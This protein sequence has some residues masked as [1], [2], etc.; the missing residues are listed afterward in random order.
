MT[1]ARVVKQLKKADGLLVTPK[2]VRF[3]DECPDG[4]VWDDPAYEAFRKLTKRT[5]SAN[6]FRGG[7][8]GSS[9]RGTCHRRQVFAFCGVKETVIRDPQLT[10]LFNDGKWRH[11][12]W[13]MMGLQSG[14]LDAVEVPYRLEK[15]RLSGS[16]DGLGYD[17]TDFGFELKGDRAF[18]RVMWGVPEKHL[19][20]IH[21]MMLATDLDTF[22][23]VIESKDSQEWR[24]IVVHRDEAMITKVEQELQ[25]LN[26]Y[27]EGNRLPE[28]LE[29]CK[30]GQGAFRTCPFA[31]RC[32]QQRSV[33]YG[34]EWTD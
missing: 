27:V 22:S 29:E 18:T 19:L 13:Q 23:Y 17:G 4:V 21:S 12:R 34:G 25:E 8:F 9:S 33:P 7:R 28:P 16:M 32:L 6:G 14:A 26:E 5:F 24:E 31:G 2:I 20:Q 10:N 30:A 15:Y 3:L 1:L 11:V